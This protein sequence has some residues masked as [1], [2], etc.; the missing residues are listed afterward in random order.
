LAD[1]KNTKNTLINYK[2]CIDANTFPNWNKKRINEISKGEIRDFIQEDFCKISE[3]YR[4]SM[5]KIL[6]AFLRYAVEQNII[7][8][9]PY[10]KLKFKKNEKIKKMLQRMRLGFFFVM[11]KKKIIK[12]FMYGLSLLHGP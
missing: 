1:C 2:Q 4:K 6:R 11:Q 9:D 3:A 12:C 7:S 10:P 5:L 8:R